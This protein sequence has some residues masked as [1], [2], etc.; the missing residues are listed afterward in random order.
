MWKQWHTIYNLAL[1][2]NGDLS[3]EDLEYVRGLMEQKFHLVQTAYYV[4]SAMKSPK[5]IC[6]EFQT[7]CFLL[8]VILLFNFFVSFY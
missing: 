2:M 1:V 4:D 6:G 7:C 5:G 3:S 8:F